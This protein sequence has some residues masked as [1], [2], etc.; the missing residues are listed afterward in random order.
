VPTTVVPKDRSRRALSAVLTLLMALGLFVALPGR[1]LAGPDEGSFFSAVNS[2]RSA[3]GLPALA[4]SG[5]L[6]AVARRQ[7]ERMASSN[8]LYHNPNLGSEVSSWQIVAE[9]V[10]YGPTWSGIQQ[11]F[12]ASPDHRANILDPQLTQLGVGTAV[13][14]DGRLWVAQVF[15]LPYGVTPPSTSGSGSGGSSSGSSSGAVSSPAQAAPV[16]LTPEQQLRQRIA[17]ARDQVAG[18]KAGK[19][20]PLI[21]AL[22][23]ST[24][25]STV[26]S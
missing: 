21:K 18:G 9:N 4:Y 6:A 15:R 14:K 22:A 2:A 24:V 26:G 25:M 23:F 19:R 16:P 13:G 12:M 3:N 1:A 10:G 20:D 8:K 11:A 17:S 5:E 7:A